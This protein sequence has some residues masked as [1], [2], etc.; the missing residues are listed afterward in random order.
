MH[1]LELT[2]SRFTVSTKFAISNQIAIEIRLSLNYITMNSAIFKNSHSTECRRPFDGQLLTECCHS[3]LRLC[4]A[5]RYIEALNISLK[6][7]DEQRRS[8]LIEFCD[9]IYI[10][11]IDD[12][13][14][15]IQRHSNDIKQVHEEWTAKYGLPKCT[16]S[17]CTKSARHYERE[18]LKSSSNSNPKP[19]PMQN[20]NENDAIYDFY[21]SIFDRIHNFVAHLYELGLR[22]DASS[23]NLSQ[24]SNDEKL[25][26]VVDS[27]GVS[28]D[29]VFAAERQH[30]KSLRKALGNAVNG[31]NPS[32]ERMKNENN[33]FMIQISAQ[34]KCRITLLDALF[35]KM[36]EIKVQKEIVN[37]L[38][39]YFVDNLYDSECIEMDIDDPEDSNIYALTQNVSVVDMMGKFI[40]SINCM[41]S[42]CYRLTDSFS[43]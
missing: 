29:K 24:E 33:K 19:I 42:I 25:E 2:L 40:R 38:K 4:E 26:K 27:K 21:E 22:V 1:I 31:F 35:Q 11:L 18:R 9:D 43:F 28:M 34:K 39:M 13:A 7:S 14:H 41:F 15:L 17:Q 3:L 5:F 6:L 8:R 23:L 32:F 37:R 36:H 10:S 20:S 12:T 30:I 16:V